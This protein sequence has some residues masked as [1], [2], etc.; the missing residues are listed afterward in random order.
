MDVEYLAP[1]FISATLQV[2][3]FGEGDLEPNRDTALVVSM[4]C[5]KYDFPQLVAAKLAL[6][7]FESR[8][9]A[10]QVGRLRL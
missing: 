8:K 1:C 6:L 7:D 5:C 3:I 4:E 2:Q 9:D 10:A